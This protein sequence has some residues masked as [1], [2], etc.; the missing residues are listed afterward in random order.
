MIVLY[1]VMSAVY[2]C[3]E[4]FKT[5]HY[6]EAF[7]FY[8]SLPGFH[9]GKCFTSKCYGPVVLNKSST[10]A[11]FTGISLQDEGLCAI[12]ICKGGLEKHVAYPRLEAVKGLVSGGVL[13]PIGYLLP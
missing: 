1:Y 7:S 10:E 5:K 9:I 4:F 6:G 3:V 8:I 2:V 13:V 12:I 11:I